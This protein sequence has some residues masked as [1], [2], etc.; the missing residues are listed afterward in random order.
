MQ[1]LV[2]YSDP[3]YCHVSDSSRNPTAILNWFYTIYEMDCHEDI[4][5]GSDIFKIFD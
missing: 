5:Q 1:K 2:I 3:A 4:L